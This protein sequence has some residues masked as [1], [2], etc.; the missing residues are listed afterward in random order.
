MPKRNLVVVEDEGEPLSNASSVK[1]A[2]TADSDEE[3]EMFITQPRIKP[4]KRGRG[5]VRG[6]EDELEDEVEV[7]GD[8]DDQEDEEEDVKQHMDIDDEEF[9]ARYGAA[10]RAHLESK[11]KTQGVRLSSQYSRFLGS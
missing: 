6:H 5:N 11:R 1:R 9:E 2:R 8:E 3:E 10:L 4:E 7:E